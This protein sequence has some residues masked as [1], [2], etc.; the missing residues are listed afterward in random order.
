MPS[1]SR[2]LFADKR[3]AFLASYGRTGNRPINP[4]SYKFGD[5]LFVTTK[6]VHTVSHAVNTNPSTHGLHVKTLNYV[7]ICCVNLI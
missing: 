1:G 3:R 6:G 7:A 5:E 4:E 2:S